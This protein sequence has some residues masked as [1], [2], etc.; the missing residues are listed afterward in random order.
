MPN[1]REHSKLTANAVAL[2]DSGNIPVAELIKEYCNYLSS[3]SAIIRIFTFPIPKGLD[4][5]ILKRMGF[6]FIIHRIRL[7]MIYTVTGLSGTAVCGDCT[8]SEM[9]IIFT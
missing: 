1:S 3:Y 2:V 9:I 7:T 4:R 8:S 6:N 5:I